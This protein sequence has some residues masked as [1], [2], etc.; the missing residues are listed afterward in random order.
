MADIV[1]HVT[2][3]EEGPEDSEEN[4]ILNDEYSQQG[5]ETY[6]IGADCQKGGVHQPVTK[7]QQNYGS[8]GSI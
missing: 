6:Q 8:L 7:L 1:G 4:W 2:D 5:V 3:Q